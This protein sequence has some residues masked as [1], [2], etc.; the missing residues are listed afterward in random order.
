MP[1]AT[2]GPEERR[3]G[4]NRR[5][6]GRTGDDGVARFENLLPGL[7]EV[8][9]ETEEKEAGEIP[10]YPCGSQLAVAQATAS[11]VSVRIGGTTRR[12]LAIYSQLSRVEMQAF[13]VNGTPLVGDNI[14]FDYRPAGSDRRLVGDAEPGRR[15]QGHALIGAGGL[16]HVEFRYRESPVKWLPISEP[17][18][19]APAVVAAS[20]LL[21][22]KQ[23][24]PMCA[25][26]FEPGT[27]VAEV[28]DLRAGRCAGWWKWSRQRGGD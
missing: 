15:G 24:V 13:K 3:D 16:W 11:G 8:T 2:G 7:Y 25:M 14:A 1:V 17:C 28:R 26:R 10:L 21:D 5:A 19:A 12:R 4:C 23:P 18:W 9:A 22:L 6:R 20:P 27:I